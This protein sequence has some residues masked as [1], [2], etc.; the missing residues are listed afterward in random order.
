[1]IPIGKSRYD[2]I[3]HELVG[4]ER[5]KR[6]LAPDIHLLLMCLQETPNALVSKEKLVVISGDKNQ[7]YVYIS[8]LRRILG[9]VDGTLSI[10][11]KYGKGYVLVY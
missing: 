5:K 3:T 9:A 2:P 11:S 7:L 10:E 6:K 8:R 1:M 4:P